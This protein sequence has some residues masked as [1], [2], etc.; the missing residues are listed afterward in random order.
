MLAE[1]NLKSQPQEEIIKAVVPTMQR[2]TWARE[3]QATKLISIAISC[4]IV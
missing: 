3:L 4:H 2:K 1:L